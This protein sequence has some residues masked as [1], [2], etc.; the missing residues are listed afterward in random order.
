M[1]GYMRPAAQRLTEEQQQRYEGAY[2]GLCHTLGRRYGLAGRMILNYD[3]TFLAMLL[4]K[5]TAERCTKR[6]LIHP[7]KGRPCACGG[8]AFEL[9]ADMSIILTW[10]QIQDGIA[11]H[12]FFGGLKYRAASLLLRR[13]YR[14]AR[15]L[16]PAFDE[17][18]RRHLEKLS[19]LEKENCPSLDAAADTFARLL[20]D[21]AHEVAQPVKRRVLEQMLYHL[22]RWVY[23]V[24]AADDLKN[25]VKTGSYNPLPLRYA[26]PGDTLTDTARQALAQTLDGSIRAM[27]AA[28]ELWDFDDYGPVIESTVYEGL[29]AVGTSVLEGTFRRETRV[30]QK[31]GGHRHA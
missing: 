10:W 7:V 18:T 21:A 19:E 17:S 1:F 22:G 4:S 16:R 30:L 3:L 29:Y 24:D 27:A 25:D 20:A 26:L 15:A 13:A 5:G 23:L 6:C 12:G 11:D 8:S 14:K 2:C 28:F 31:K 9:A